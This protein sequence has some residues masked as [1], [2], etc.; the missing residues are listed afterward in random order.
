MGKLTPGTETQP[1]TLPQNQTE[2]APS[3]PK[4]GILPTT[5]KPHP[6]EKPPFLKIGQNQPHLVRK[7]DEANTQTPTR[8]MYGG[9]RTLIFPK[10]LIYGTHTP[11]PQVRT[12]QFRAPYSAYR[13][14]GAIYKPLSISPPHESAIHRRDSV[15]PHLF[16]ALP[17][18]TATTTAT[19]IFDNRTILAQQ[20]PMSPRHH[21]HSQ[22]TFR[23]M[24][25]LF[26]PRSTKPVGSR[27]TL[28]PEATTDGHRRQPAVPAIDTPLPPQ[29]PQPAVIALQATSRRN[30]A[31]NQ[32]TTN[33]ITS[34]TP[35]NR[36]RQQR[37]R[38]DHA[39]PHPM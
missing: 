16:S 22:K 9:F 1:S 33:K 38:P 37:Q 24:P 21:P 3:R 29:V 31:T 4:T 6:R 35:S 23:K 18:T 7:R 26:K 5:V 11:I 28:L 17:R 12:L 25:P 34:T 13:V 27:T 15:P 8:L 10:W 36:R 39:E 30:P 14:L 20:P 19:Q 32:K 2:S